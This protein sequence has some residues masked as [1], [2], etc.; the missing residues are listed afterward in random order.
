MCCKM[1]VAHQ[2]PSEPEKLNLVFNSNSAFTSLPFKD[3][4]LVQ[5]SYKL[6]LDE[7]IAVAVRNTKLWTLSEFQCMENDDE[8]FWTWGISAKTLIRYLQ[9]GQPQSSFVK[10]HNYIAYRSQQVYQE[11]I[12]T[13]YNMRLVHKKDPVK[14]T[15]YKLLMNSLYGKHG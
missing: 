1:P 15:L 11:F 9:R 14:N 6:E 4:F 13:V 2:N 5:I 8:K 10:I 12:E 3:Y 7:E